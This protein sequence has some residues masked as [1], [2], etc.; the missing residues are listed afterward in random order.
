MYTVSNSRLEKTEYMTRNCKTVLAQL[1]YALNLKHY[2]AL[3]PGSAHQGLCKARRQTQGF[4]TPTPL[5]GDWERAAFIQF[6]A[7]SEVAEYA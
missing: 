2:N 7:S 1:T 3:L 6:F 5:L 4:S